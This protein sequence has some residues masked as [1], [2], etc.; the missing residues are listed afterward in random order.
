ML[1]FIGDLIWGKVLIVV[2]VAL[3]V[4]FTVASRFVQFRYFGRMFGALR[5][6]L[7]SARHSAASLSKAAGHISSA[8]S[9]RV[10][11]SGTSIISGASSGIS[12][13][14]RA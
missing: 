13:V 7:R 6:G 3:G 10:G 1:V 2:L 9:P 14:R 12:S 5:R 8:S 11:T 4:W